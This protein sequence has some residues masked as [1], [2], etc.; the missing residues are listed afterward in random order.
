MST[1]HSSTTLQHT[2]LVSWRRRSLRAKSVL[3]A[4]IADV[5]FSSKFEPAEPPSVS[6]LSESESSADAEQRSSH[7]ARVRAVNASSKEQME[8]CC[9]SMVKTVA[10][11]TL[12][13]TL[14]DGN[15]SAEPNTS[16]NLYI[17]IL[18][19]EG[20]HAPRL[21][22]QS[23]NFDR[24]AGARQHLCLDCDLMTLSLAHQMHGVRGT[25]AVEGRPVV[26][27]RRLKQTVACAI[28]PY[29]RC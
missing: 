26:R 20:P 27:E 8:K 4:P 22:D 25:L 17:V 6:K 2:S 16:C 23:G 7:C 9:V 18:T 28:S 3:S 13:R 10:I 29:V 15:G 1:A 24:G 5:K 21:V 12:G 14:E 19:T 11:L